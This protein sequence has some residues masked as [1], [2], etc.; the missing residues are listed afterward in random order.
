MRW[1]FS[2]TW[3]GAAGR[4]PKQAPNGLKSRYSSTLLHRRE[5]LFH[6]DR[7]GKGSP[8]ELGVVVAGL[9]P[10]GFPLLRPQILH[11]MILLGGK[12]KEPVSRSIGGDTSLVHPADGE[13]LDNA[14]M[15][16]LAGP[17]IFCV[18]GPF[19]LV[20]HDAIII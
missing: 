7:Q 8:V 19:V 1:H 16:A 15:G 10:E 2:S 20:D 9:Q 3:Q 13:D 18:K 11:R 17:G 12:P 4:G 6:I 14:G 5:Q